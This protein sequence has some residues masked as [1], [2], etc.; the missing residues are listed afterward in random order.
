MYTHT[1]KIDMNH[2]LYTTRFLVLFLNISAK[3]SIQPLMVIT[4]ASEL[5]LKELQR[6]IQDP[7]IN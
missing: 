7:K 1:H 6:I 5:I 2:H 4:N 3:L